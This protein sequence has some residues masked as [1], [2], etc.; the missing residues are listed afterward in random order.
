MDRLMIQRIILEQEFASLSEEIAEVEKWAS[1]LKFIWKPVTLK[2]SEKIYP[3]NDYQKACF[4]LS[5]IYK[6]L[7]STAGLSQLAFKKSD[8]EYQCAYIKSF[9]IMRA[10]A[11]DEILYDSI[12]RTVQHEEGKI[13]YVGYDFNLFV[14]D[15][16]E[17]IQDDY[18]KRLDDSLNLYEDDSFMDLYFYNGGNDIW[19]Q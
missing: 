5:R 1:E 18:R 19:W 12:F 10:K 4:A 8:D 3:L 6:E 17:N 15:L 14:T 9:Y 16:N 13:Y 7:S 11:I 2:G